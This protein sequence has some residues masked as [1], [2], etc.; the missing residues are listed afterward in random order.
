M[1]LK[2]FIVVSMCV[3]VA[4]LFAGYRYNKTVS[5]AY[6]TQYDQEPNRGPVRNLRFTLFEA[7]IRPN[8]IQIKS[9]LVQIL[10]EDKTNV[11]QGLIVR[12]MVGAEKLGIGTVQKSNEQTRGRAMFRLAPGEYELFD[13]SQPASKAVVTVEP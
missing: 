1:N 12:R 8:E 7:G 5:P 4:T 6:A 2:Y 10:L 11:A 3:A 9:G 13:P